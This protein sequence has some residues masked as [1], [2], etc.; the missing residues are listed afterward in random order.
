MHMCNLTLFCDLYLRKNLI[1]WNLVRF[2]FIYVLLEYKLFKIFIFDILIV[3]VIVLADKC[4]QLFWV[5]NRCIKSHLSETSCQTKKR[6]N[7]NKT[8]KN[9]Y[10][11]TKN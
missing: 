11:S 8:S 6:V 2:I 9:E 10:K 1:M 7:K 5:L 3:K 4:A